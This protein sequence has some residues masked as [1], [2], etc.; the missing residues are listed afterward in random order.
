MSGKPAAKSPRR[1]DQLARI[2]SLTAP[3]CQISPQE[4]IH[5]IDLINDEAQR[6]NSDED[7]RLLLQAGLK[8]ADLAL[9]APK[10]A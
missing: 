9:V 10:A 6:A 2:R 1:S 7:K 4:A 8:I 3:D 5:L